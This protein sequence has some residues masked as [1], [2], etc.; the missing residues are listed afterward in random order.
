MEAAPLTLTPRRTR[1]VERLGVAYFDGWL[2]A[3]AGGLIAFSVFTL[4]VA[5]PDAVQ[6]QPLYFALRQTL[7][8]VVGIALMVAVAKID[9]S[10]FREIRVGI[11]SLMI[12]SI[13]LVLMFGAAARG[14]RR[15][16]ELPY[17]RFQPSELAKLLLIV[18]LAAFVI[19]RNR[20]GT[21]M[22]QTLRILALGLVPAGL[23][24]LQPDLGT[25]IVLMVITIAILFLAGVPWRH[26]AVIG[27]LAA[28]AVSF[29][30]V[31]APAVGLPSPLHGYQQDRL[32]AFLHPSN[33]PSDA[34]Y[35]VNQS[36]TAIGSGEK[37]GR[38]DDSTQTKL[39][40]LPERHTDFVFAVVGERFGFAGAALVLSLFALLIWRILR[41]L[42]LS[43]NL[44]GTLIAGG[45][46]AMLMFQILVNVGMTLGIMPV[47][48]VTLPLMSYGG[49]SVIA[50]F[51][52]IGLLQSIHTQAQ[53]STSPRSRAPIPLLR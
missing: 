17:F 30:L 51:L 23:V 36:V 15:W 4:A 22:R 45:I 8:A 27:G 43:K 20:R 35:Q 14:S 48:G 26:F 47:T 53:L 31:I 19:E 39:L 1:V 7:Y 38:G 10:R 42:A 28:A 3:A 46:A 6:G 34:S 24:F 29:V 21:P 18:A 50:T 37:T 33:D 49:S 40:F 13:C 12:G 32:T 2:L 25:G 9:Y 44:F 11:Y 41:I 16:I 52:A 5:T